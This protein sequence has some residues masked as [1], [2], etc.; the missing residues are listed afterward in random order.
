MGAGKTFLG[1]QLA[2]QLG[3]EFVDTDKIISSRFNCPV[4][5]LFTSMGEEEFRKLESA[6]LKE[7]IAG[8]KSA[9]VATGGGLPCYN[10]NMSLMLDSGLTIFL[11][12]PV[13]VLV[14]RIKNDSQRPLINRHK[15]KL[16]E[17]VSMELHKRRPYYEK[18]I[19]VLK[20]P[21]IQEIRS[22]IEGKL[23]FL[24]H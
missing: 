13:T 6:I 23:Q 24:N 14:N 2:K 9:I 15:T 21:T 5:S 12:W 4:D 10:D 3:L 17:Y 20:N 8:N 11:D 7:L 18:S 1:N 22:F 19:L 16:A